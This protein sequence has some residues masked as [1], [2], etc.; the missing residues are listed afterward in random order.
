MLRV[1][2]QK[3]KKPRAPWTLQLQKE[4][5]KGVLLGLSLACLLQLR[6]PGAL[7]FEDF[8]ILTHAKACSATDS[9]T[10]RYYIRIF[11]W[12]KHF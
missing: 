12:E 1:R 7:G 10:L 9:V 11:N 4:C 5:V 2:V 3:T 6:V 8:S